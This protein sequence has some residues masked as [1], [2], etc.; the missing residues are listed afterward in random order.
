MA[1]AEGI[2]Q[3][4]APVAEKTLHFPDS[5]G[6]F[7]PEN[8]RQAEAIVSLRSDLQA[9]FRGVRDVTVRGNLFIYYDPDDTRKSVSPDVF[10][11]LNHDMGERKTYKLWVEGKPPDFAMEVVSP[12]SRIRNRTD[13]KELYARLEIGEYFLFQPDP[14]RPAPRLVGYELWGGKYLEMPSVLGP[15]GALEIRSEQLGVSLRVEGERLRVRNLETGEDYEWH[16]DRHV[17]QIAAERARRAAEEAA[18]VAKEQSRRDA[19]AR[20]AAEEQSR[21]D[22]RARRAAERR[23]AELQAQ[24]EM[25]GQQETGEV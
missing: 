2:R 10:V 25:I 11:V 24:L 23:L 20:R 4:A 9:H 16:E 8:H 5:D 12:S 13:K 22:C 7:L 17:R 6:R 3:Q 21:R 18:R 15:G 1:D 14:G 19:R